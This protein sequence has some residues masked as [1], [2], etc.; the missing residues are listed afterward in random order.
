M[1]FG[2]DL[3]SVFEEK[4]EESI[5]KDESIPKAQKR[6]HVEEE[7]INEEQEAKKAKGLQ[8]SEIEADDHYGNQNV[9]Y[10]LVK[11]DENRLEQLYHNE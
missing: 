4:P 7:E 8:S 6:P 1:D 10:K 3:F 2:G 5:E 11:I 9:K